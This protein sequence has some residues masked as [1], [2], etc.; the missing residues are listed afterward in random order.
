MAKLA[1]LAKCTY[2]SGHGPDDFKC[3][4]PA[5]TQDDVFEGTY[6]ADLGCFNQ[7]G[8][9]DSNKRYH[10]CVCESRK[11]KQ[12]W[13]YAEWTR[14]GNTTPQFQFAGPFSKDEAQRQYI[15]KMKS[16]N[17]GRGQW[18]TIAGIA[19]KVLRPKTDKHGKP[20]DL[21]LVRPLNKRSSGLPD[22]RNILAGSTTSVAKITTTKARGK[23]K[24]TSKP[25]RTCDHQTLRLLHDMNV[26]VKAY[27]RAAIVGGDIPSQEAI[28]EARDILTAARQRVGKVAKSDQPRDAELRTL[29]A[30]IYGKVPKVKD[31]KV[32]P[33]QYV[34]T[35]D[36]VFLWDQDLDA[37]E[38]A[39]STV[40]VDEPQVDP[41]GGMNITLTWLSL[42]SPEGELIH[43]WMPKATANRHGGMGDMQIKNVWRVE[44]HGIAAMFHALQQKILNDKPSLREKPKFQPRSRKDLNQTQQTAYRD[45]NTAMLFHGTRSVNVMGIMREGL[46]LPRQ[47]VGV[48]ITGA[49]FGPGH[50]WADDWK[51]SA[52]YCSLSSSYWAR[53]SGSVSGRAAFMFVADVVLGQ[54]HVADG[55]RGYTSP[56]RGAHAIFG[57]AGHS[58]V[59]NNEFITF[60]NMQNQLRYL[61]EFSTR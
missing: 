37:F 11:N 55:Y 25:S 22:G 45:S 60:D 43:S 56:P 5:A 3:F 44:R 54:L 46:R 39:L 51:K 42:S 50:Y 49:M 40:T 34:L 18:T 59:Q 17:I 35:G 4:G 10:G 20:K 2:P 30:L 9:V 36:N 41:Y 58:G 21:Y 57:K 13:F 26:G 31:Q 16:K 48:A 12:V 24:A 52:G 27:A 61:V 19:A 6:L 14:T 23:K 15:K 38:S 28:D 29:T 7:D 53:G 1:K 47:L 33:S 8:G 32:D